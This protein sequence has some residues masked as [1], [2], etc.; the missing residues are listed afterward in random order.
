M[1][2][3]FYSYKG[4]V[5]RTMA[6]AN[7]AELFYQA[8][9]KVLIVDWDLEAPG[10]ERFF[11]LNLEEILDKPGV[12]DMLLGYKRQMA[13]ELPA[14]E[15]EPLPFE[16]PDQFIVD[17]YPDVSGQGYLWLL[18]AGRR[19]KEH[20][21][22]YAHAVLVFDWQDFYQNWEGELY[23]EWL[24]QQFEQMADI[25]LIDSRTGVTEMG[26]VCTYQLADTVVMFCTP[27]Q[28]SLDGTYEMARNFT[29][30]RVQGLRRGR[31]LN[32][33][34]IPARVE[35]A[36]SDLLDKFQREFIY[37][38]K[39]FVPQTKGIDIQ[40]L[41]QLGIPY[42]PKYAYKEAVAVRESG[43][44]SAEDMSDA[45]VSLA[46]VMD[47][48]ASP[49]HIFICYER[50]VE[51]DE[52]LALQLYEALREHCDVFIDQT[53]LVGTNWAE[54]IQAELE[55]CD[56]FIPL[57]SEHSVHS[58]MVEEQIRTAHHLGKVG[59]GKPRILPVRVAYTEPFDYPLSAYLDRLNWAFWKSEA[60]TEPLI[61]DLLTAIAGGELSI[62][63]RVK[64]EIVRPTEPVDLP[65]PRPSADPIRLELPSG[66]M[67]PESK[68]YIEREG[69]A[70]CQT[71]I[72]RQGVTITIKAPFQLG[73]SSL[74]VRTMEHAAAAGK[75]VAFLDL[76]LLD[77]DTLENP[78]A[79][80]RTL[81]HWITNEL[82]LADEVDRFWEARL[83]HAQRCTSYI[84]RH[85][86]HEVDGSLILA[87]D[88]V[89]HMF[90]CPFRSDFFGMLR[91][92][93]NSRRPGND[94]KRLDLVL[95]MSTEP[96]LLIDDLKQSP[97]NVGQVIELDDFTPDQVR[98]LNARHGS[99]LSEA[100]LARLMSLI[101][102]H[103][104]LVRRA[105]YLVASGQIDAETLMA[106]AARD[107]GP[108]G[109]HLRRHLFR[110]RD[111][112]DLR[113]AMAQIVAH[114]TCSDDLLF[115][116]LR[117]AGLARRAGP[118]VIPRYGLYDAYF[119]ER[120]HV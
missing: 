114:N 34:V 62:A 51:P 6:L 8:G 39:D 11:A 79:F 56:Y 66:T 44:A 76:Q 98:D 86:L 50:N 12:I 70:L 71:D 41:W 60:D 80:F 99:P 120:F 13:K 108:F 111:K 94:W 63:G 106:N 27:N 107:D 55:T 35:R 2:F 26:G 3:T 25:V 32:V 10:L 113:Q 14:L 19:S 119:R 20:F 29:T 72:A 92:W 30:P 89:D 87:M 105:L 43:R 22:E 49:A 104:Y 15:G 17:V 24:R 57:L 116:R 21:A 100:Q 64:A 48:L 97:F 96:Y 68:F 118:A 82:D 101:G 7:V 74:L 33:L 53:M 54:R 1:I 85:V 83:G 84:R 46:K 93:H 18:P 91:S 58:E 112:P 73:K 61:N 117:G 69:D 90:D 59:A 42:I 109:D 65:R 9:L 78:E 95:V 52:P 102:G 103:P 45:F 81:C 5:G 23:F 16:Q 115:F 88:E 37:L 77:R 47:R 36:E 31:P 28:Q 38:F 75:A 4:G 67:D 40:Q 110:F